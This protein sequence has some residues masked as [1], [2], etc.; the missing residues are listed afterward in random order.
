LDELIKEKSN[1]V[2]EG[3]GDMFSLEEIKQRLNEKL[4]RNAE[5]KE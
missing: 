1:A 3:G 4:E 5:M 2:G